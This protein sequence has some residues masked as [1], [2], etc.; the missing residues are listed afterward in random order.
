MEKYRKDYIGEYFVRAR[1]QD[2][3]IISENRE[4][5]PNTIPEF[6]HTGNA[7]VIG[8]G[9]SRND[10][11]LHYLINHGGGHKGRKKLS[12]YGCNALYRDATPNFLVATSQHICQEIA[13]SGYADDNVVLAHAEQI[14]KFP[15]K[16]HLVPYDKYW[17]AGA[18]ATWLACFDGHKVVYLLGFD[19]QVIKGKNTNVYAGTAGYESPDYAEVNDSSWIT[20]MYSIFDT[21]ADVDFVWVNPTVMPEQWK[22]AQNLRQ[23]DLRNFIYAADLGA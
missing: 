13:E 22:Y 14:V 16:Y 5:V 12:T 8:N 7:V 3:N 1:A 15:G 20:N 2:K 11:P 18:I 17:N 9:P 19:N 23:I 6:S 21:Y 4:W 10:L